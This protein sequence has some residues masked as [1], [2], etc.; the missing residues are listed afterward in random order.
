M[1]PDSWMPHRRADGETVGF[2]VFD[3]DLFVPHDLL[4]RPLAGPVEWDEA[5]A[6]V[7]ERGLSWLAEP[8]VLQLEPPRRVRVVEVSPARVVV[9]DDDF[10]AAQNVDARDLQR[11]EFELPLQVGL[12]PLDPR[13]HWS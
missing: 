1:I 8:L 13:V 3:G 10:G 4:G 6:A 7:E 5:E 2:I 11:W 12:R 9:V